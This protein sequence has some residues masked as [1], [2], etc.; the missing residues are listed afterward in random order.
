[1]GYS[2][3][4][5]TKPVSIYDVQRALGTSECD[6]GSLCIHANINK[7]A[8]Y[9][10]VKTS[11]DDTN[12]LDVVKESERQTVHY[13]LTPISSDKMLAMLRQ[14]VSH[15]NRQT[16]WNEAK[17]QIVEWTYTRPSGGASSPY[18]L[19]DFIESP[20]AG[21]GRGTNGATT[22][23]GYYHSTK[24]PIVFGTRW[25]IGI[26]SLK[27]VSD[28]IVVETGGSGAGWYA[29]PY[30]NTGTGYI[31]SGN[32]VKGSYCYEGLRYAD[33]GARFGAASNQN[34]NMNS[35]WVIPIN[36]LMTSSNLFS[37][38]WRFGIAVFV[39][40]ISGNNVIPNDTVD[41][42]TSRYPLSSISSDIASN[43]NKFSVDM[44]TNQVLAQ[45]MAAYVDAKGTTDFDCI[46]IFVK[47]TNNT[48]Q[49]G[50]INA[51][52][53]Q[54]LNGA[55]ATFYSLP[56]GDTDFKI[57]VEG[58]G[59]GVPSGNESKTTGSWTLK[60]MWS[61]T[62][63]GN[64]S[65]PSAQRYPINFLVVYWSGSSTPVS[66]RAY[67]I[68]VDFDWTMYDGSPE[69]GTFYDENILYTGNN[70]ITV[71]GTIYYG[72]ILRGGPNIIMQNIRTFAVT[73]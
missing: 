52:T 73:Y 57:H 68:S 15:S 69:Y 34:I 38:S 16:E 53:Y 67:N 18:R 51:R 63:T 50:G 29:D 7:W 39:K 30:T 35:T 46:P 13:G 11:S 28:N 9:K 21:E 12:K 47:Y 49:G 65:T 58:A 20:N 6:L 60:S 25:E 37:E 44:C 17:A 72:T 66:G 23:A 71:N 33:Y 2:G 43:V 54:I 45:K 10:P 24:P 40:G 61:G 8:W 32:A 5:I 42:F 31:G 59:G 27:N 62:Y 55:N 1:M 48:V 3:G 70:T 36:Y 4:L 22:N 19:T 26:G 14:D 41:I 56:Q 64:A